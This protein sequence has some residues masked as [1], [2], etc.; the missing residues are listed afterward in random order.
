MVS[1]LHITLNVF[2]YIRPLCHS[3]FPSRCQIHLGSR[4]LSCGGTPLRRNRSSHSKLITPFVLGALSSAVPIFS[5]VWSALHPVCVASR[6]VI[7]L[8][9]PKFSSNLAGFFSRDGPA[10]SHSNAVSSH[11]KASGGASLCA[12][13]FYC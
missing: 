4:W 11:T 13:V 6:F 7:F 8:L 3:P 5:G 1:L 2:S 10:S 9:A 12:P